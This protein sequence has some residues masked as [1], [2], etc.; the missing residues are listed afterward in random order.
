[1][2]ADFLPS[3]TAARSE[4]RPNR[5]AMP[6]KAAVPAP[7][8]APTENNEAAGPPKVCYLDTFLESARLLGATAPRRCAPLA[9]N[10]QPPTLS[11]F[12]PP[13]S[14]LAADSPRTQV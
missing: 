1:M 6:R 9:P 14:P 2:S 13:T 4:P 10:P 11:P 3:R 7:E 8:A 12:P 5:V